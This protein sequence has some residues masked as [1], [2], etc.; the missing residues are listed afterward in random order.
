MPLSKK[1]KKCFRYFD[2][3]KTQAKTIVFG[4]GHDM[5]S[6]GKY[7]DRG[8]LVDSGRVIHEGDPQLLSAEYKMI[9]IN[10][11]EASRDNPTLTLDGSSKA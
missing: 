1:K 8:V 6:F 7:C 9:N 10:N 5:E 2:V 4:V 3:L 11:S